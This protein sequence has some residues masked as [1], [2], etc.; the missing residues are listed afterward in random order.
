[1]PGAQCTR[2]RLPRQ[3]LFLAFPNDMSASGVRAPAPTA[4][5]CTETTCSLWHIFAGTNP[6]F[7]RKD[8]LRRALPSTSWPPGI[9]GHF[10]ENVRG[11]LE[12][13]TA[14]STIPILLGATTEHDPEPEARLDCGTH[15][16]K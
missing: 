10:V 5:C 11:E 8:R 6:Q 16:R 9:A 4:A 14:G 12:P 7:A 1:M 15:C 2:R 13:L 3:G